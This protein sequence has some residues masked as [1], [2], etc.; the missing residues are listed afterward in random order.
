M[1]QDAPTSFAYEAQT[2]QGQPLSGTIDAPDAEHASNLLQSLRVRVL[3]ID[4]VGFA[5]RSA[6]LRGEDFA[7][8]NQQLAHLTAAGLPVEHGLR[9]IAQDMRSGRLAET[10]RT[11]AGELER[12]TPMGEAFD[13]HREKFPPLYGRLVEAGVRSGNLSGMLLNLGRHLELVNRLR[14]MMWRATAYPLIVLVVLLVVLLFISGWIIPQFESL[15]ADFGVRLPQVTQLL[16]GTSGWLPPLL[17]GF[18][19]AIALV[20]LLWPILRLSGGDQVVVE[21]LVLPAPL[22]GPVLRRNMIA[23]WCDALRLGV[24]AGLDLPR[25]IG[26]ANEAVGSRALRRDGE[27]LITTLEQGRPLDEAALRL[28]MIPATVSAT[29]ELGRG[30]AQLSET[31]AALSE[32]YQQQAE[33]RLNLIPA[34]LTPLMLIFTAVIIGLV[35]LGL[36]APLISLIQAVSGG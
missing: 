32:L 10:I 8:F 17:I 23:R 21:A 26:L 33:V 7:S 19:A 3:R 36:F 5:A 12:G 20:V 1:S 15:F 14:G 35:V 27:T 2:E 34:I 29:I 4:P 25:A 31:L 16:L 22:V 18:L 30:K 28:R 11:V 9:L 6:P 13:R 24:D